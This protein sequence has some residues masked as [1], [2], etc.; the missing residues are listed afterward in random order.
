MSSSSAMVAP[1]PTILTRQFLLTC[2]AGVTLFASF[3]LLTAVLP[4][5]VRDDLG[6]STTAVGLIVGVFSIAALL[7]RLFIGREID[8]TGAKR[9]L[10]VGAGLFL[11]AG[12]L[13]MFANTVPLVLGVR[14]VHGLG[15]ACFHTASFAFIAQI[16]PPSR[17]GEAMGIWGLMSTFATAIS[18]YLG[19]LIRDAT[20][21]TTLFA[22]AAGG[23]AAAL[24]LLTFVTDPGPDENVSSAS[25]GGLFEPSVMPAAVLILLSNLV[26]GAIAAFIIVYAE[27]RDIANSGLYFTVFAVAVLASRVF[28]GRLADRLSRLAVVLPTF[29][30]TILAMG[31]LALTSSLALLLLTGVLFGLAF[32]AGQPALNAFAVDLVEPARRGAGMATFTSFFEAGI[33]MGA[34]GMGAVAGITGYSMMFALTAIFPIIALVYGFAVARP[35]ERAHHQ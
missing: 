28:G 15:M 18:P 17:R 4:L 13:Y 25:R 10:L 5:Y 16:S 33:G 31:T 35:A 11:L 34:I 1:S 30:L 21:M 26:Y 9:F 20:G 22:I 8:R 27:D 3:Q 32:G 2:A 12:I 24:V 19:L 6:G 23:A 29:V 7:P 14:A